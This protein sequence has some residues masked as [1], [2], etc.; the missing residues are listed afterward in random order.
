MI[1]MMTIPVP[2]TP[3][4]AKTPVM[5]GKPGTAADCAGG[6]VLRIATPVIRWIFSNGG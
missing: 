4:P 5:V 2:V 1:S 6:L 3:A